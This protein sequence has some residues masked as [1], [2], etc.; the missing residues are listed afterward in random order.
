MRLVAVGRAQ[1]LSDAS[2]ARSAGKRAASG[3]R[4]RP[5]RARGQRHVEL[6]DLAGEQTEMLERLQH[7]GLG[8]GAAGAL[9]VREAVA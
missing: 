9:G 4:R 2:A 5:R 8:G 7:D 6:G 3:V 1:S